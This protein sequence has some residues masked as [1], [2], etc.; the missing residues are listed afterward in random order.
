MKELFLGVP[1]EDILTFHLIARFIVCKGL[2]EKNYISSSILIPKAQIDCSSEQ[3]LDQWVV[4]EVGLA[5]T[6]AN[7]HCL[8][9]EE[10][11]TP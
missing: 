5:A 11:P 10:E 9:D 1:R 4:I 2:E 7:V 3:I 8:I 6:A